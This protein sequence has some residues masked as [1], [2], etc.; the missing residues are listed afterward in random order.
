MKEFA[1]AVCHDRIPSQVAAETT[2]GAGG[3]RASGTR[4]D[5]LH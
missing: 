3:N 4:S 2:T 5:T 1:R